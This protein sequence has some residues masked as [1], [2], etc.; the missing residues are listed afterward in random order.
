[1]GRGVKE[2]MA[3]SQQA[4]RLIV[5]SPKV[6]WSPE[7]LNIFINTSTEQT[8]T[9]RLWSSQGTA[10]AGSGEGKWG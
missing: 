4:E 2:Q 10:A 6:T 5:E 7:W 8:G 3:K 1:M 9:V